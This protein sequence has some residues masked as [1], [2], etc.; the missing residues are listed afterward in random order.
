MLFALNYH[1]FVNCVVGESVLETVKQILEACKTR[2]N[3][4][5]F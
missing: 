1:E 4:S 3:V 5:V 2:L